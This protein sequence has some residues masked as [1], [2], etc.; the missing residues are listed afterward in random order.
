MAEFTKGLKPGHKYHIHINERTGQHPKWRNQALFYDIE[1]LNSKGEK[2]F[3]FDSTSFLTSGTF[4]G[5]DF[6]NLYGFNLKEN[7]V[8]FTRH[9]KCSRNNERFS[10]NHLVEWIKEIMGGYTNLLVMNLK[11]N[12]QV[13]KHSDASELKLSK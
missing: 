2:I 5:P 1:F 7:F 10:L 8:S 13:M 6:F 9:R 3:S 12:W 11:F 4:E